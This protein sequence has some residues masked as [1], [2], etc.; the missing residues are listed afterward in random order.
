SVRGDSER[1][2][3]GAGADR[4]RRAGAP[5][6]VGAG[7][8][9]GAAWCSPRGGQA[10]A[11]LWAIARGRAALPEGV[12]PTPRGVVESR[13]RAPRERGVGGATGG[14]G[15]PRGCGPGLAGGVGCATGGGA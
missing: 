13:G 6:L 12:R 9:R 5:R 1:A 4:Q 11:C 10:G 8:S 7:W 15:P 14:G 3:G 2:G